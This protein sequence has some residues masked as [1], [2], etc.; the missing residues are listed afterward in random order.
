MTS[1]QVIEELLPELVVWL[2]PLKNR[3]R[4]WWMADAGF[5]NDGCISL[6]AILHIEQRLRR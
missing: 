6:Q 5:V 3:S 2:G 4:P 1:S